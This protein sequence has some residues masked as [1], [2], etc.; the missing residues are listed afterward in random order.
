MF[1]R[2]DQNTESPNTKGKTSRN[3]NGMALSGE[4][5]IALSD[6]DNAPNQ[7]EWIDLGG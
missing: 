7:D 2:H 4:V 1:R 6:P 3:V 5:P